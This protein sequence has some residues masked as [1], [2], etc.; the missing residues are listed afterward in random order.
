MHSVIIK[1]LMIH[2]RNTLFLRRM[3]GLSPVLRQ[4]R[5]K[6]MFFYYYSVYFNDCRNYKKIRAIKA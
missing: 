3:G 2:F 6:I 1:M 5:L 4:R